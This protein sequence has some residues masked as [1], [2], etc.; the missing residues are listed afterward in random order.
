MLRAG[1]GGGGGGPSAAP[2][3]R[4]EGRGLL[5]TGRARGSPESPWLPGRAPQ[6]RGLK[7]RRGREA[8][9]AGGEDARAE[10]RGRGGGLE[11]GEG[12]DPAGG[13]ARCSEAQGG[14]RPRGAGLGALI[15]PRAV[16]L[17]GGALQP[18][19]LNSKVGELHPSRAEIPARGEGRGRSDPGEVEVTLLDCSP[20]EGQAVGAGW[21]P[22][23]TRR[24]SWAG[25]GTTR[26]SARGGSIWSR[27]P[28]GRVALGHQ[29]VED[30]QVGGG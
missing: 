12:W 29:Q 8:G 21:G 30:S 25:Q 26:L 4:W 17:L 28:A 5:C 16:M 11:S 14:Q 7:R 9:E 24:E 10:G 20:L 1:G 2:G 22:R 6:T 19:G 15:P 27:S 13:R 3:G 23:T 18:S